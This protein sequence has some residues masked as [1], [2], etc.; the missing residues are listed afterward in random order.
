MAFQ[1]ASVYKSEGFKRTLKLSQGGLIATAES[2]SGLIHL[3]EVEESLRLFVPRGPGAQSRS[4]AAQLPKVLL[5][6]LHISNPIATISLRNVILTS[7]DDIDAVLDTDG[8]VPL[9]DTVTSDLESN[10]SEGLDN[11]EH[12]PDSLTSTHTFSGD[13]TGPPHRTRYVATNSIQNDV[14]YSAERPA[15]AATDVSEP[16]YEPRPFSPL[17]PHQAPNFHPINDIP[18][19]SESSYRRVLEKVIEVARRTIFP[20]EGLNLD[21]TALR[22]TNGNSLEGSPFGIRA[23]NPIAHDMKIGAAGELYVSLAEGAFVF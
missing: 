23:Q 17:A 7:I 18:S 2:D 15:S 12:T 8:I 10:T 13:Q 19:I 9:P 1:N 4:Y 3:E 6:Y 5:R 22:S 16:R 11:D 21:V 14:L 20:L